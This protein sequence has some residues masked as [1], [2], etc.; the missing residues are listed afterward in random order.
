MTIPTKVGI[1]HSLGPTAS[2]VVG[3]EENSA[4]AAIDPTRP[5]L[6]QE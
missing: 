5:L 3:V 4:L 1:A 6:H 2:P